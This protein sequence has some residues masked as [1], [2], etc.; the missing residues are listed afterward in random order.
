MA[1]VLDERVC[2]NFGKIR[3]EFP[4]GLFAKR[5][6]FGDVPFPDGAFVVERIA[7]APVD[8]IERT[9]RSKVDA[10]DGERR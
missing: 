4:G 7:A 2:G 9:I 6:L 8:S 10:N 5:M 1:Q 3:A